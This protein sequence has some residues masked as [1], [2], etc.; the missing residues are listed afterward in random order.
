MQQV[1]VEYHGLKVF[2]NSSGILKIFKM[3]VSA[4]QKCPV[5]FYAL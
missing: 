1:P 4:F 3:H 2:K 5:G